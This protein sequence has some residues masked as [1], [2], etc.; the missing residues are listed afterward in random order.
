MT[1]LVQKHYGSVSERVVREDTVEISEL[2]PGVEYVA[3]VMAH[4][5]GGSAAHHFD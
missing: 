5:K 2:W 1:N 4:S 3:R